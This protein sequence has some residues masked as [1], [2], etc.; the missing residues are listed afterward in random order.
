M[1]SKVQRRKQVSRLHEELPQKVSPAW[2]WDREQRVR[3]DSLARFLL[4][5]RN[6]P[7]APLVRDKTRG[8]SE[9]GKDGATLLRNGGFSSLR[10]GCQ[11]QMVKGGPMAN[12][13]PIPEPRPIFKY[14][15]CDCGL[16]VR[17]KGDGRGEATADEDQLHYLGAC[18]D[19]GRTASLMIDSQAPEVVA[20]PAAEPDPED[21]EGDTEDK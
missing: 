3:V 21:R 16:L 17:L 13:C 15:H 5:R 19:C 10:S 1:R 18:P 7:S 20:V 4:G 2:V 9:E 14:V 11:S 6:A 12:S 8:K